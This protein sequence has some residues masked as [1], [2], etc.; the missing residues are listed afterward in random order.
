MCIHNP[1]GETYTQTNPKIARIQ[2]KAR[3]EVGRPQQK[4]VKEQKI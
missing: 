3:H 1:R 4:I 2:V